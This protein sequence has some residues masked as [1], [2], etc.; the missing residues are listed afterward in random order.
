[1]YENGDVV[2]GRILEMDAP[3]RLLLTYGWERPA[4][5]GIPPE[6]TTVEITLVDSGGGTLLR[7]VHRGLPRAEI[8]SHQVGWQFFL[9]RLSM[10]LE[11]TPA[12]TL[13]TGTKT[14]AAD[15]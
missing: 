10:A 9:T 12:A 1:V 4:A 7:L 13:S 3:S 8:E 5:R 11:A 2:R 15:G 14:G 6:S